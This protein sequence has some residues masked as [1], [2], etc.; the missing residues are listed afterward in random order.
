MSDFTLFLKETCD[1]LHNMPELGLKEF[2]TSAYLAERLKEFGYA[3]ETNVGG[4]GVVAALKGNAPGPTI[5]LRADMDALLHIVDGKEVTI[6]S[7]GHDAHC[8]MV[9]TVAKEMAR[10]GLKKGCLKIIF[11]PA[12]EILA[13][14]LAMIEAKVID[15][16]DIIMGVHLR[17]IQEAKVGQATPGLYHGASTILQAT[18]EGVSAHGARPHLGVNVIDAACLAVQAV[19][20]IHLDPIVPTTVKATKLQAGSASSNIIP[21]KAELAF[22]LRSQEND[23]MEELIKKTT[24]TIEAAAVSIGAKLTINSVKGVPAAEYDQEMIGIAREAIVSV[25]GEQGLLDPITSPGG[26]DFHFFVKHKPS[27]KAVYI[28]IGVDLTP[29]LH[30]PDMTFNKDALINGVNI[31]LKMMDLLGV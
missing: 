13:G 28:G 1:A 11:Q 25:L 22:D 17:P 30:H 16:V 5:G 14:A 7:C 29:G 23:K 18:I 26:E 21:D 4:T 27:I 6:H 24:Q 2:K 9:L 15:D 12:E 3:V 8:A 31:F 19:N 10:R 20:T